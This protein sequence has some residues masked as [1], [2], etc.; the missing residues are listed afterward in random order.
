MP[1]EIGQALL[2]WVVLYA[3]LLGA[4]GFV[5]Y[6]ARGFARQRYSNVT[7]LRLASIVA[8]VLALVVWLLLLLR[9]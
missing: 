7:L 5:L 8:F 2:I 1:S 6:V 3:G 4:V 9:A